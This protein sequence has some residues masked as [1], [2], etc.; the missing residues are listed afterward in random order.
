MA[1]DVDVISDPDMDIVVPALIAQDTSFLAGDNSSFGGDNAREE[2]AE[3]NSQFINGKKRIDSPHKIK[4]ALLANES[5]EGVS[6]SPFKK[7]KSEHETNSRSSSSSSLVSSSSTTVSETLTA[8]SSLSGAASPSKLAAPKSPSSFPLSSSSTN[9]TPTQQMLPVKKIIKAHKFP[10]LT[11]T[12]SADSSSSPSSKSTA[13][14][15]S[16]NSASETSGTFLFT[17]F[18]LFSHSHMIRF[19]CTNFPS[20]HRL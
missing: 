19:C 14:A 7:F 9:T 13:R 10:P 4:E 11:F 5:T 12:S 16:E 3:K 8:S 15:P 1:I 2:S 18:L 20:H 6:T 17:N